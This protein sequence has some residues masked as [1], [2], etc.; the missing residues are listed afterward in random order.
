M[1]TLPSVF[2]YNQ[3]LSIVGALGVALWEV[4]DILPATDNSEIGAMSL[5]PILLPFEIIF[6]VYSILPSVPFVNTWPD[7]P[8]GICNLL[9]IVSI[10]LLS[11]VNFYF[12]KYPLKMDF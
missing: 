7:S 6:A 4:I 11:L 1:S 5:I 12:H 8:P 9:A 3:P 10:S 2:V